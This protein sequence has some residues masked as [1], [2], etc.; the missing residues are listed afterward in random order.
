M[1][2]NMNNNQLQMPDKVQVEENQD[3][4]FGRFTLQP[5]EKGYGVTLGNSF[6]RVLLSSIQGTAIIGIK[7]SEVLHEFQTIPGV[8]EDVSEIILNLKEIRIKHNDKKVNKLTFQVK[9]PGVWTA[10]SLAD[11]APEAIEIMN[12]EHL[13]ANLAKDANFEVEIRLARGKGY[14]QSEE[15]VMT[16]FPLGMLPIDAVYTPIV[17]AIYE[18]EPYRVGHKTDYEK[19][20]LDVTT[21]GTTSPFEAIN[22]SAKILFDHIKLFMGADEIIEE[23][24][25]AVNPEDELKEQERNRMKKILLTPVEELELSVRAHNCLRAAGIKN[26]SELVHLQESELLKFRNFG[27]K[28]LTELTDVVK[29]YGLEFGMN[30]DKILRDDLHKHL[31]LNEAF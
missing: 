1:K 7:I 2:S 21:D 18:I 11:A 15:Q 30:V 25:H 9:G 29:L 26:L 4:N 24:V 12:P 27:K 28:S 13:I 19:L 16:D 31:E 23:K 20:I 17:N 22:Y 3:L 6:R 14:V 5:L 8:L 10:Q